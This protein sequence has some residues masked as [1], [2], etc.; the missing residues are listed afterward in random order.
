MMC[1]F[2]TATLRR[3]SLVGLLALAGQAG[4]ETTA[5]CQMP[6]TAQFPL[7][8][9]WTFTNG[10]GLG[11][12]F[13]SQQYGGTTYEGKSIFSFT[14]GNNK[15]TRR[16]AV[17]PSVYNLD[18]VN[19]LRIGY[20]WSENGGRSGQSTL[21]LSFGGTLLATFTT[22]QGDGNG[23]QAGLITAQ[24]GAVI[25]AA[26]GRR[27]GTT[28]SILPM[29]GGNAINGATSS[30][31][32]SA[33]AVTWYYLQLPATA[34]KSGQL[35][36]EDPG[37]PGASGL[38]DDQRIYLPQVAQPYLCLRK[39]QNGGAAGQPF[40][41]SST[42]LDFS[43]S[44]GSS[45]SAVTIAPPA[46]KQSY[47]KTPVPA[48][49]T[50]PSNVTLTESAPGYTISRVD[51]DKPSDESG[52]ASQLTV[53]GT[54]P[55]QLT[56]LPFGAMTTCTVYN[57]A[58]TDL[59]N[60]A[61]I[62]A[63][64]KQFSRKNATDQVS[65]SLSS[66]GTAPKTLTTSGSAPSYLV[67]QL[68]DTNYIYRTYNASS[69]GL[70]IV[71]P[72]YTLS[73]SQVGSTNLSTNYDVT[74]QCVNSTQ[75]NSTTNLPGGTLS[76]P[77][78]FTFQPSLDIVNLGDTITCTISNTAKKTG[79]L[80]VKK[81]GPVISMPSG[82]SDVNVTYTITLSNPAT[83]GIPGSN[84]L[85][86]ITVT[87]TYTNGTYVSAT[88]P[89]GGTLTAP[90]PT[91]PGGTVT[92]TLPNWASNDSNDRVMTVTLKM[93]TLAAAQALEAG[94]RN[95]TDTANY[96]STRYNGFGVSQGTDA[97]VPASVTTNL[98]LVEQPVKTVRN[99]TKAGAVGSSAKGD[100]GDTLEYC[101][102]VN[103]YS[104]LS[105]DN[106][107]IRD[108]VSGNLAPVSGSAYTLNYGVGGATGNTSSQSSPITQTIGSI[109]AATASGP[110]I[111]KLCF[112]AKIQ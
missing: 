104:D 90:S 105:A 85:R 62:V 16:F 34:P 74:Y 32:D 29:P 89:T 27:L 45:A 43:K 18:D 106:Y 26:D 51:C 3:L 63:L 64:N 102:T 98:I 66:S 23:Q 6:S 88:T 28:A 55:I 21:N 49:V 79:S 82:T 54:A 46:L 65:L 78:S 61:P 107:T 44:G 59:V 13:S 14:D 84:T 93:P 77:Y 70:Q 37:V 83:G 109:P 19:F 95:V 5:S 57:E 99:V 31:A 67:G 15:E 80:V 108:S 12:S 41:F 69:V 48:R 101:I 111:G 11:D 71:Y 94:K 75:G 1:R 4:A 40:T 58:T 25:Y 17:T 112:Q 103:N 100:P 86:N 53:N 24:N 97:G 73:E 10:G 47:A 50:D 8:T 30:A 52:A 33:S 20:V 60:K 2:A 39:Q 92:W 42:G 22:T 96:T 87:D 35:M 110:G 72:Q 7:T 9:A 81:S 38:Y 68:Q 91:G 36:V 76:S 56:S